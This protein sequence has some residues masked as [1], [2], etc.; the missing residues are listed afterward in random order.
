LRRILP[1]LHRQPAVAKGT[2]RTN[3]SPIAPLDFLFSV[4]AKSTFDAI[5]FCTD[6]LITYLFSVCYKMG[7]M[8]QPGSLRFRL[9]LFAV[10]GGIS[11]NGNLCLRDMLQAT[12]FFAQQL[13]LSTVRTSGRGGG[14]CFL[15]LAM[16]QSELLHFV[17]QSVSTDIQKFGRSDLVPMRLPQ[18][19]FY[20]R[21]LNF[22]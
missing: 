6:S 14:R 22:F 11:H 16:A 20:Q 9:G 4:S 7:E 21:V 2:P 19:H 5:P 15:L 3:K 8:F 10:N 12:T 13:Q 1:G 18:S 17:T